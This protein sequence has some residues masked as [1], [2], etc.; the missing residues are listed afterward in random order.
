[1][2]MLVDFKNVLF[3]YLDMYNTLTFRGQK[4]GGI[5]GFIT[6]FCY[7]VN[8]H[9]PNT[10]LICDD[11]P[12]YLK[13]KVYPDYK[14]NRKKIVPSPE[15][16]KYIKLSIKQCKEF[17]DKFNIPYWAV[18]GYECDD[19]IAIFCKEN[20]EEKIIIISN[21]DDL[22]QL[23]TENVSIYSKKTF[24]TKESFIEKFGIEPDK[25]SSILA[26][27]GSHNNVPNL[28]RNLGIKTALKIIKNEKEF[29]KLLYI[30][31]EK[32]KENLGVVSLPFK[33]IPCTSIKKA[34]F[35]EREIINFLIRN[36]NIKITSPMEECFNF[37]AR[38]GK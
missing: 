27:A 26:M 4:T 6:E 5:Y 15:R 18:D 17:I 30:Y 37:L 25:W 8:L 28:Y 21:D 20:H 38:G 16:S 34:F 23:L 31:S 33:D 36:Y 2:I 35:D 3:K 14:L 9:K 1:M 12:P 10:I 22:Y 13:S 7:Q 11:S 19:L 29:E 24:H 32:F